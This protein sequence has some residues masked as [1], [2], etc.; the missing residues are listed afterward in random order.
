M[1]RFFS[2]DSGGNGD[3]RWTS[4]LFPTLM[5]GQ[6]KLHCPV[7]STEYSQHTKHNRVVYVSL[8]FSRHKTSLLDSAIQPLSYWDSTTSASCVPGS[9]RVYNAPNVTVSCNNYGNLSFWGTKVS[10]HSQLCNSSFNGI[11]SSESHKNWP[12]SDTLSTDTMITTT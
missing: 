6:Q 11:R 8:S 4:S 12:D 3:S 9:G 5:M 7:C 2:R 1:G 10:D